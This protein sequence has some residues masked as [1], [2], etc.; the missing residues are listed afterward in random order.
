MSLYITG[1][2]LKTFT[3]ITALAAA[4]AT[5]LENNIILRTKKMI[6][7]WCF[8]DFSDLD[9][10]TDEYKEIQL[11]QKLLSERLYIR[12]NQDVK[13]ARIII[14][15]GGS[16]KKGNDW[17]YSLGEVEELMTDEIKDLLEDHR[18]WDSEKAYKEKP[19]TGTLLLKGD[20]T[21][22]SEIGLRE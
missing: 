21:Y 3:S 13:S 5:T 16:E 22:E 4:D 8:K 7:K 19:K 2:E 1:T 18:D 14:G 17:Q 10:T 15:K 12:D 9:I 6:D 20:L 11:A